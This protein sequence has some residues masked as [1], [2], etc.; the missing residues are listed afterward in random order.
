M[1]K[2]TVTVQAYD[3]STGQKKS[4][5]MGI[6]HN[7][8]AQKAL[9][10]GWTHLSTFISRNEI[11]IGLALERQGWINAGTQRSGDFRYWFPLQ[12]SSLEPIPF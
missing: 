6:D 12:S 8:D 11:E 4:F 7:I 1:K 9:E 5:S 10:Q 2:L 3:A